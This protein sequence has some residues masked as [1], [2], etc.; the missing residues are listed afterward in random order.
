[1]ATA[2]PAPAQVSLV[3]GNT[4]VDD[5]VLKEEVNQFFVAVDPCAGKDSNFY[6]ICSTVLTSDNT[7]IVIGSECINQSARVHTLAMI[8]A[9]HV[10]RCRRSSP[11]IANAQACIILESSLP[12]ITEH[13]SLQLMTTDL[14][15]Y[16]IHSFAETRINRVQAINDL[17]NS[18][19]QRKLAFH[20]DFIPVESKNEVLKQLKSFARVRRN[21]IVSYRDI[22]HSD[23]NIINTL[24]GS[25][26]Y[27]NHYQ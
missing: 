19:D 26:H 20:S 23:V 5:V 24:L 25:Y 11:F 13:I 10:K 16:I 17:K 21:F 9:S 15:D 18:L 22:A 12:S 3:F 14:H 6:V 1:M 7:C 2:A 27:A 8:I 4:Q